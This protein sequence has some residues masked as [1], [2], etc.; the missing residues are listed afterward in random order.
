ME[1][2]AWLAFNFLGSTFRRFTEA[3]VYICIQCQKMLPICVISTPCSKP[4]MHWG[5]FWLF[6]VDG[7][8]CRLQ[9][10]WTLASAV[11]LWLPVFAQS[12]PMGKFAESCLWSVPAAARL[13]LQMLEWPG[14]RA[15]HTWQCGSCSPRPSSKTYQC[16][17]GLPLSHQPN[18]AT[19][20]T[21]GKTPIDLNEMRIRP[22]ETSF[23][24]IS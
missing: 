22:S 13:L 14:G 5:Q 6:V 23:Q 10:S 12:L 15:R 11:A 3:L 4:G 19:E 16:R 24:F 21:A 2:Q 9:E 7:T 17:D 18:P 8:V 1:V 20:K